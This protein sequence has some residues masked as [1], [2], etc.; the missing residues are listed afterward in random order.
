VSFG[1][2][3]FVFAGHAVFPAIYT[4]MEKPE[5]YPAML[6]KARSRLLRR[7]LHF[8]SFVTLR[9]GSLGFDHPDTPRCLTTPT[10]DASRLHPDVRRHAAIT[11]DPIKTYVIVGL[12]CL[13]IGSA[14]YALYG[15]QVMDEVTLNLPAGVA[16]TIALALITVNPF[17]K[18]ALTMDPVAR[19]L[20]KGLLGIDVAS[21]TNRSTTA[22]ALKARGLRTGLGLSALA[23]A[24]TVPFFAVFMSLIG[25]FLT[26]TVSVIFP[27]ACYLKMFEDEVT[28]GERALN[29]GIMVLGGFCVVAGSVSAV[30]GIAGEIG[31]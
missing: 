6:D 19:G 26:L 16:S 10:T 5:E 1:L 7:G 14:G 15:D 28:D 11:L 4:S 24:A 29:W 17:S 13:V 3:A 18:F 22:S 23:T 12:T 8:P 27:S 2:L 21:E 31:F 9:P 20:E 25:S 30:Q